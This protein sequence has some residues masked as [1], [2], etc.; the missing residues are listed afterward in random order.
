MKK[1]TKA[2]LTSLLLLVTTMTASALTYYVDAVNGNDLFA[3]L[4]LTA[5]KK[6][7]QA[8]ANLPLA[9]GDVVLVRAGTYVNSGTNPIFS[10]SKSGDATAPI[11]FKNYQNEKPVLEFDSWN[12]IEITNGASYIEING[13]EVQGFKGAV[14]SRTV[15]RAEAQYGTYATCA[16][17]TLAALFNGNGIVV[18]DKSKTTII[19][20]SH[21]I[22]IK[23]CK[24]HDCGGG[25]IAIS[26]ADYVTIE[27]NETYR[28]GWYSVYANSGISVYQPYKFDN[29]TGYKIII[30][31]NKSYLNDSKVKWQVG[32]KFS[33]GNG[34]IID[35]LRNTQNG[36]VYGIY[37]GKTLVANNVTFGNGGSGLHAFQSNNV[38]IVHNISYQDGQRVGYNDGSVYANTTANVQILNNIVVGVSGKRINTNFSNTAHTVNYNIFYLGSAPLIAGANDLGGSPLFVNPTLD[39][40]TANFQVLGISPAVNSGISFPAVT[41]DISGKPRSLGF[42]P[43]RGAYEFGSVG[44]QEM[45]NPNVKIYPSVTTGNLTV[46]GAKSFDIVNALGQV[47]RRESA[48]SS[49]QIVNLS[50][51]QSGFYLLR[52]MDTE[53]GVFV[54]KVVKQ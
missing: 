49:L 47:V 52:G 34:I 45:N 9:P 7:L 46:E 14:D 15:A 13:F 18:Q 5:A 35:D 22:V 6:T 30:R 27:N 50:N 29:E 3:G 31:N 42:K 23:N 36:S 41:T 33:D 17:L 12:G 48:A 53:G 8:A 32:C 19:D 28:N 21:H 16:N 25:G 10:I 40:A 37:R 1:I 38:D 51:L 54:K 24:V 44:V 39:P 4:S 43:D 11:V 2:T 26:G 20:N